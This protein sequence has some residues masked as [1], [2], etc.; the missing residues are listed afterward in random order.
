MTPKLKVT[1]RNFIGASSAAAI[2]APAL[3][4][5]T[6]SDKIRI[7][8]IGMGGKGRG[9]LRA[10]L[11]APN[12]ECVAVCDVYT[13]HLAQ[14][15]QDSKNPRVK[16]TMEYREILDDPSIDAIIAAPPDHWHSRI[17]IDAVSA[18]KDIYLEKPFT[19]TMNEARETVDAVNASGQVFQFGHQRRSEPRWYKAREIVKSG[20]L[21]SVHNVHAFW[22]LSTLH[23]AGGWPGDLRQYTPPKACTA[24]NI[25]WK[26][27]LGTAPQRAF[28][29]VRFR[30]WRFF[31]DYSTGLC[32]DLQSHLV[33]AAN[34]VLQFGIP[35]TC[36][37]Q[38]QF[39]RV[40]DGRDWPG[41]WNS[42][43]NFEKLGISLHGSVSVNN[44][45]RGVGVIIYGTEAA[46]EINDG[47]IRV[48]PEATTDGYAALGGTKTMK[49]SE[50]N[51]DLFEEYGPETWPE[52]EDNKLNFIS[53]VRSRKVAN[54]DINSAW[55]EMATNT[56]SVESWRNQRAYKYVPGRR[57]VAP[58]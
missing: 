57:D 28:D 42:I 7:A 40:H 52:M 48:Y 11:S 15:A 26:R 54:A 55:E 21:G 25:D 37:A 20:K 17:C 8:G 29:P 6:P 38:G 50:R 1:R 13:E 49:G 31:K 46:M 47:T 9:D 5:G 23:S 39:A 14:A 53:C 16:Q 30:R 18:G 4:Q 45:Q 41:E 2:G 24:D 35:D 27:W 34:I 36:I 3:L 51:R 56:M 58:V 33:D 19:L 10:V 22:Y 44:G 12:V 43:Y 32:G